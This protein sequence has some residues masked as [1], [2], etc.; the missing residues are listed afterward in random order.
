[1]NR[2][3]SGM[4][5]VLLGLA[6][7]FNSSA[8][9]YQLF[10]NLLTTNEPTLVPPTNSTTGLPRPTPYGTA[11]FTLNTDIP[12][13][14]MTV[15]VFNLDITGFF[16]PANA[17][18]P[19][20]TNDDLRAAHIHAA[21]TAGAPAFPVRWGFFG[22]PDNDINPD[23]LVVTPFAAGVGGTFTSVWD[24]PEGNPTGV[25]DLASQI[26]NILAGRAY[27]NFHT[28]QNPGGE[29]RGSLELVPE[30]ATTGFMAL[31]L[32]AFALR[33]LRRRKQ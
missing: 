22:S 5:A 18:T 31:G 19:D 33:S 1:M 28:V 25:T 9:T 2:I 11:L 12:Q 7:S 21:D 14:T 6:L 13:M 17:Q 30:P 23:N 16:D 26:P 8:A 20:D 24:A 10:A 27:I 15:S 29:I 4:Y 3:R 32:G